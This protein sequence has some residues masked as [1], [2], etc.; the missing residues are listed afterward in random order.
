MKKIFLVMI[1]FLFTTGCVQIE[2]ASLDTLINQIVESKITIQNTIMRGYKYYLPKSLTSQKVDNFNEVIRSKHYDY[3]FYVDL[4]SYYNHK[5]MNYVVNSDN[6]FSYVI[7]HD[8]KKGIVNIS[9]LSDDL[10]LLRVSYNY[11]N[12]EVKVRQEDLKTALSNVLIILS[13][14]SYNDDA[15]KSF[16][17][18]DILSA[19]EE[20]I[21][22]FDNEEDR[23]NYIKYQESIFE[24]DEE[25]YDPD[26][27]N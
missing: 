14:L 1:I 5:D 20:Q 4:V 9:D 17:G 11:A 21:N 19:K 3:Y 6:Y 15:I 10:Y 24:E 12:I 2:E 16:M 27:I 22:I 13:S 7:N 8:D 25:D 23:T 26:V 18:S